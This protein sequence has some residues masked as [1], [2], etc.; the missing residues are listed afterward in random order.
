MLFAKV[1]FLSN[2]INYSNFFF[3]F[4]N[5]KFILDNFDDFCAVNKKF[6]VIDDD[7]CQFIFLPIR[8]YQVLLDYIMLI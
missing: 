3:I 4:N 1:C 6:M 5:S 8:F 2:L 7:N